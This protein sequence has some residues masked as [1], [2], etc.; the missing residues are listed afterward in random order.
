[1]VPQS[2]AGV[3][4]LNPVAAL[5]LAMRNILL[6]ARA[7]E[8]TLLLKLTASSLIMFVVG[9]SVFRALKARFSDYL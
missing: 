8:G 4:E 7:P 6:D 5:V 2:F 3:Y 9:W 1:M